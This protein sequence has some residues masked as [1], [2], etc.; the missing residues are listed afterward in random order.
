MKRPRILGLDLGSITTGWCVF[1]G[2][3]LVDYGKM[4]PGSLADSHAVK[5]HN[6][7][8]WLAEMLRKQR[9]S[10]L[11]VERPYPG[12]RRNV[13]GVL[14][15]FYG[16]LELTWYA[17]AG[18]ELPTENQIGPK[19]VKYALKLPH[20]KS[21]EKRKQQMV[22]W[23]NHTYNLSLCYRRADRRGLR[24]EADAADAIAV[25]H[26]WNARRRSV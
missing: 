25:V 15:M 11:V 26:A 22:T 12:P 24:T 14:M 5:L 1:S 4:H 8:V 21:Y 9:I 19:D 23:A 13:Y 18:T 17:H 7:H 20:V 6:F 10:Q 3:T 16:V 2:T